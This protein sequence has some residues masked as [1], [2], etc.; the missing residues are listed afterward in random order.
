[1]NDNWIKPEGS[2]D[3][4]IFDNM[5]VTVRTKIATEVKGTL[6]LDGQNDEGQI[7]LFVSYNSSPFANTVRNEVF[8]LTQEQL[9]QY[10]YKGPE[11]VLIAPR[12]AT[13][14]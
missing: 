4:I 1:M 6:H 2:I 3:P 13:R 5:P 11:C 8:Y 7:K 12:K 9:I 10:Q 14:A